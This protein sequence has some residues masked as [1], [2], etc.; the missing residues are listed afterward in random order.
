MYLARLE[1]HGFKS[2]AQRT[3]LTFNSGLTALVGPN[4]CGKSNI[5]DAIRWVLGEQRARLLRADRMEQVIF[6]GSKTRK[7]LGMA[8]VS[9]TF[10]N[11]RGLL[12]APY[13][14]IRITRRLYRDGYSEY[15]LNGVLCRLRDIQELLWDTGMGTDAYSVIELG[16]VEGLLSEGAEG[17]RR[18]LE[19]AA[20]ITRFR[21]HRQLA[22]RKLDNTAADLARVYDLIAE[23]ERQVRALERQ[24]RK[25]QERQRLEA[26]I[27][28]LERRL[29]EHEQETLN[30][31]WEELQERLRAVEAESSLAQT[32]RAQRAAELGSL[33]ERLSAL[34]EH[35][36][37]D[38]AERDRQAEALQRLQAERLRKELSLKHIEERTRQLAER[39]EALETREGALTE[40]QRQI[41]AELAQLQGELG[42]LQ[43]AWQEA[44]TALLERKS[45][46]EAARKSWEQVRAERDRLTRQLYEIRLE[47]ERRSSDRAQRA[48]RLETLE[49]ARATLQTELLRRQ[50]RLQ[51]LAEQNERLQAAWEVHVRKQTELE[52]E[53]AHRERRLQSLKTEQ[54]A[55]QAR[56]A[57]LEAE[58]RW[59]EEFL[60]AHEGF[61]APVRF[62]LSRPNAGIRPWPVLDLLEVDPADEAALSAALGPLAEAL[63]VETWQEA[64]EGA[65]LLRE[66]GQGKALFI[67][68]E[69]L[70]E[71]AP[72][73]EIPPG[74]VRLAERVRPRDPRWKGLRDQLLG[75]VAWVPD[76]ENISS[77]T[78]RY[79]D[80]LWVSPNGDR[81]EGPAY[82]RTGGDE[83]SFVLNV[84]SARR[85]LK[86]LKRLRRA[87]M[88]RSA[89][90]ETS[91]SEEARALEVLK[92]ALKEHARALR[93]LERGRERISQEQARLEAEHRLLKKEDEALERERQ[94]LEQSRPE[95]ET[96]QL[97]QSASEI[98]YALARQEALYTHWEGRVREL[99]TAWTEALTAEQAARLAYAEAHNRIE[100]LSR[101]AEPLARELLQLER[102]RDEAYRRRMSALEELE[103]LRTELRGLEA[104]LQGHQVALKALQRR[105]L[106]R[107]AMIRELRAQLRRHEASLR[108]TERRLSV[109]GELRQELLVAC[110]RL[111]TE[112]AHLEARRAELEARPSTEEIQADLFDPQAAAAE[113]EHARTRLAEIGPT[114]ALALEAYQEERERLRFLYAQRDDIEAAMRDVR[115]TLEEATE[116]AHR[117][118]RQTFEAIREHFRTVL[119]LLF[120]EV[121]EADLRLSDPSNPLES[122]VLPYLRPRGKRPSSI[123]QLSGGEKALT[124]LALL[125]ALY[126]VKPSPFCI[127]DEV[128]AP[129]DDANTMRFLRL[130]EG[131]RDRTQF[132]V[133][134]HNKRTMEAAETLYGITME[135]PGVSKVV[136]ARLL[137]V[138]S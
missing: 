78:A 131:F 70:P 110:A 32:E 130:L 122:D 31:K 7:P 114:N 98:S 49:G 20:G 37:Q 14:E 59:L 42:E 66:S 50:E 18:L 101:E 9:L 92:E 85:R 61:G 111:E 40:R 17:R 104:E 13:T 64:L 93:D 35:L 77:L 73:P 79:P 118:F 121:E 124:A 74:A 44:E 45:A 12:P 1:L 90:L 100:A 69:G 117:R 57:H 27:W 125:F 3:V 96:K 87:L 88:A 134:T 138:P 71:S 67:V 109:L 108:D 68:L 72:W 95:W 103:N 105:C 30:R 97:E 51:T 52:A 5:V 129:L 11:D 24:A 15:L 119:G 38:Q 41:A 99:E 25:A 39:I 112:R 75:A 106:E 43:T 86:E 120:E 19:E 133:V 123:Q 81:L 48:A 89:E 8:E 56:L 4:G 84:F 16:M 82:W 2:F 113:L 60:S 33:E 47:I 80:L 102:E 26:R 126:L 23:V 46:L 55:T 63:V 58:E 107:E 54:E 135:E 29:L 128:D 132:I 127:L 91:L 28:A 65:R 10:H 115:R 94:A 137:E 83:A 62:L 53:Q 34:E 76:W 21:Q 136:A 22:L 36:G 6:N 116:E